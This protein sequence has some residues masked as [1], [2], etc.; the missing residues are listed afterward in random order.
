MEGYSRSKED[1]RERIILKYNQYIMEENVL[2]CLGDWAENTD[3]VLCNGDSDLLPPLVK[4]DEIRFSYNQYK[5]KRSYVSCTI[6]AAVWMLSDLMNYE[7][8][9]DEI[10]EIDELSYERG[11]IRGQWWYVQ[12]AVKLVADR[13]NEKMEKK[14]AYYRISKY[15]NELIEDVIGKLYTID[16]NMHPTKEWSEDRKDWMID[17]TDFW[18]ITNWHSLDIVCKEWQRTVKDSWSTPYY[19]LKNKVS[20]VTNFW[21]NFY[22]YVPVGD[23]L[24]EVKRLNEIKA[25]CNLLIEHLGTLWHLVN[26][27]NFQWVLHYTADKLRKK[28]D[29]CNNE[30]KKYT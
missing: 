2:G 24:E 5:N 7:F 11:R 19:W 8:T 4:K 30:L 16:W 18:K 9:Y 25:E 26:D 17:G 22:V 15:D 6:F 3:Y 28:I 14:V 1:F 13:W 23:N 12:S 29:D 20:A 10:K 27:S 21:A